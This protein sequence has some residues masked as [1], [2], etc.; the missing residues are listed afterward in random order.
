M[1]GFSYRWFVSFSVVVSF[2]HAGASTAAGQVVAGGARVPGTTVPREAP[3]LNWS[4]VTVSEFSLGGM[5][6]YLKKQPFRAFSLEPVEGSQRWVERSYRWDTQGMPVVD[7]TKVY[8]SGVRMVYAVT[9]FVNVGN[10]W[11]KSAVISIAAL[12]PIA[13]EST[14]ARLGT[15]RTVANGRGSDP[16]TLHRA[17]VA[18]VL[19]YQPGLTVPHRPR[20]PD[21]CLL[22]SE[23]S[24]KGAQLQASC[25]L[26]E[27]GQ[28]VDLPN[29][30]RI[31]RVGNS[32][33]VMVA[34]SLVDDLAGVTIVRVGQGRY[35]AL[36]G[37]GPAY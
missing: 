9:G 21:E 18:Q 12:M 11:Y 13:S 20:R 19:G 32:Y 27:P 2:V 7:E 10:T 1:S 36:K 14:A 16:A 15:R 29:Q 37:L 4:D 24:S 25:V 23:Y 34:G 35:Y 31:I 17:P 33:R 26:L 22:S 6:A 8:P 3:L 5:D 30:I 28:A